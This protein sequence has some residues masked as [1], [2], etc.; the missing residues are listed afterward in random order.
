MPLAR[1]RGVLGRLEARMS[2]SRRGLEI[3]RDC[4]AMAASE[5]H[6]RISGNRLQGL[7]GPA[8]FHGALGLRR[9]PQRAW[10]PERSSLAMLR[11]NV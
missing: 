1:E 9:P 10:P 2:A 3:S 6:F 8:V 11:E 4:D 5:E 7:T